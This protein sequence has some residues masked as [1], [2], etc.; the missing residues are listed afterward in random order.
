MSHK[1]YILLLWL[2]STALALHAD[3]K[4]GRAS[5]LFQLSGVVTDANTGQPVEFASVLLAESGL[6]A[7]TGEKGQFTIKGVPRGKNTVTVQCLGYKKST[8]PMN[9]ERNVEG[10]VLKIQAD[11]LKLDEVTVVARRKQDEATTSYTIDRTTLDQQQ[12]LNIADISTLLPGGKTVNPSLMNDT[13]MALRSGSQEKGNASFGTA[14][15]IDGLRLD[16]NAA[17]GET[18]GASTRTLSTSN[19]ESVEIVTGIPS[20]EYGD[21]SNGIVKVQTRRGKSP[22]IVEGSLNQ[23]TRQIAVSK[24]FDLRT[25]T[26][27]HRLQTSD[28]RLQTSDHRL[29]TSDHRQQTSDHRQQKSFGVLNVSFEHARSFSDAASPHTAYQRNILSLHYMN[30]FFRQT[31]PLTLN[32]G[33]TGNIGGYS[34]EADPDEELDDYSKARD[35]ALRG[36]INLQWLLNKPWL[37]NLQLSASF[38]Y[39]DRK[40][41]TNTHTSSASTQ[42]YIHAT[43]QGY[44]MAMSVESLE[45]S[46]V[47]SEGSKVKSLHSQLSTLNPQIILGPTGYWYVLGF[48]DSKPLSWSAKLKADCNRRF[49]SVANRFAVGAQY[50]ASRNNGRGTYYDDIAVAPT[51]REYR[52]DELPTMHNL[53]LYA[54]DKI[55]IPLPSVLKPQTPNINPQSSLEL[56]AG[57][58]DDITMISGSDYGTVSSLSPRVNTRYILWRSQRSLW[59]TDLELHAGWGKSVKLPSFQ[60]LYPSP[61]YSDLLAFSS[62][63]TADNVSY[64]AYHT[65]PSRAQYNPSLRWQHTNQWDLGVEFNIKGTRVSLSAFHHKTHGSYMAEKTYTPFS[66]RYT[67]PSAAQQS[68]IPAADRAFIIDHETGTVSVYDKSQ[69]SNLN[70]QTKELPYTDKHTYV[71]NQHYINATPLSRYG[72][73]WIVDFAQIKTLRTQLRLDG[74]YYRYKSTDDTFFADV[75][76][77]ISNVT[78]SG[79]PFQYIGYYRGTSVTTA[80]SSASASVSNGSLSKQLNLNATITTH[81]PRI[82]LIVA[83]RLES[84]L[85]SFRRSLSQQADGSSRGFMLD[86]KEG[87]TGEPYDGV[88][89]NKFVVVYPEYYSTWEN[90]SELIPFTDAFLAAKDNDQKLYNDLSQLIVRSNFAYTMNPNRLSAYYSANLS[91]TKEIG[92]HI[93]IS[94]YA[95]NFFNNMKQVHSSQTDLYTSL[96][97]SSYIPSY[98]Y[99]LS[100][101]LKI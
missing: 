71:I 88:T 40:Q 3:D 8:W 68:G 4:P 82:R 28:H 56:T 25:Q 95:N 1:A 27:D 66:Y 90:P 78:S 52:Y 72:L 70:P 38:S 65:Y 96:F 46:D 50:Q 53:G 16:N 18:A 42:P 59:I 57:L 45:L 32:V 86:G 76:L 77:G 41:E 54:E 15:E 48:N 13:R 37:T 93:S 80:G 10:M 67:A 5:A 19:V 91:V 92:D 49:G 30:I 99:G 74:N 24:G 75:P 60:V 55:I 9:L 26:S 36:N 43:E 81:I 87:Y 83:L 51:W 100:L 58:R 23:H 101:R 33:L 98:Y 22:F 34:S 20:V 79:Q 7:I 47:S 11:N 85:Y 2:L 14:I 97:G 35:N 84:T 6:W 39:Q 89:E 94:F 61:A 31:M 63:S 29:Q 73:E 17:S 69:T 62:T 64:Y 12:I 21:L 44:N